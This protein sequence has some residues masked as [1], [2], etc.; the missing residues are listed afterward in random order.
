[1]ASAMILS[2]DMEKAFDSLRWDYL[3]A[4][5]KQLGLGQKFIKWTSLLYN[6]SSARVRTGRTISPEYCIKRGTRQG[7]PLSP[8]LFALAIEPFA[9]ACRSGEWYEGIL[10][11]GRT[12]YV[13]LYADDL[14]L[15]LRDGRRDMPRIFTLLDRFVRLSG[16]QVT[17]LRLKPFG[18]QTKNRLD[19]W[20]GN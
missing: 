5:M 10:T 4:T 17:G 8:L 14:L 18:Y 15:Y 9:E 20:K 11:G 16:L 2:I 7:C 13:S 12:H 19:N 6:T 1:M 3:F